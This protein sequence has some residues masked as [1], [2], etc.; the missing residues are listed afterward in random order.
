MSAVRAGEMLYSGDKGYVTLFAVEHNGKRGALLRYVNP[1]RARLHAVDTQGMLE[2]EEAVSV[3]E[4]DQSLAFCVFTGA[5]D[6]VHA[7]ADITEFKG[8]CDVD[9]IHRH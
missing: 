9:A 2:M 5:Y 7:G 4:R 3:L 1:N 8:E 6:L